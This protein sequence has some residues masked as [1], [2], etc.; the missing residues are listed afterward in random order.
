MNIP[1]HLVDP[2]DDCIGEVDATEER[3][4]RLAS[5]IKADAQ[6]M[7]LR[8]KDDFARRERL[9][10]WALAYERCA[11]ELGKVG[12]AIASTHLNFGRAYNAELERREFAHDC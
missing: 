6:G 2:V 8:T 11:V 1:F 5:A 10:G 9:L 12:S 4:R 3:L 7:Q